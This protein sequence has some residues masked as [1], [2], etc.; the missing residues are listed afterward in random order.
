MSREDENI[1]AL[2]LKAVDTSNLSDVYKPKFKDFLIAYKD[3]FSTRNKV[4]N[5]I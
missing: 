1:E 5:V 4:I 3:V 2:L